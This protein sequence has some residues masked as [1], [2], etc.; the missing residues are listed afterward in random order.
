L[1]YSAEF[2]HGANGNIHIIITIKAKVAH[3]EDDL[4]KL[5][6]ITSI[7]ELALWTMMMNEKSHHGRAT[8]SQK[9]KG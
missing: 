9:K 2:K 6:E 3:F 8:Q 1:I 5:K 4:P 7:I